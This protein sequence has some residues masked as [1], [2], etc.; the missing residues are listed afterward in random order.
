MPAEQLDLTALAARL[1]R[2]ED[3]KAIET[4][5]SRYAWHVPR[6][7]VDELVDLFTE[8]AEFQSGP[9]LLKGSQAL[10]G[11]FAELTPNHSVPLVSN[12]IIEIDGDS[13]RST[14][15]M[16]GPWIGADRPAFVGWYEDELRREKGRWLFHRRHFR[17]HEQPKPVA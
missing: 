16:M 4:L 5:I 7:E 15:K 13:A 12:F 9:R 8:D 6:C 11:Y 17:R 1:R 10:R 3:I 2:L 14:C